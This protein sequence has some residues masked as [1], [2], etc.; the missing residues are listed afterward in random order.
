MLREDRLQE[1]IGQSA[2]PTGVLPRLERLTSSADFPEL[3]EKS[4][5][6][7]V[8]ILAASSYFARVL[9]A[10]VSLVHW[11]F[12][13]GSLY[14]PVRKK[15]I[16]SELDQFIGEKVD[17][18]SFC[19]G[20][21]AVKR[22]AFLRIG[23]RD[24]L[25]LTGMPE[26]TRSLS[27][28]A[29]LCLDRAVEVT[30]AQLKR[31]YGTPVQEPE[32][33]SSK[34]AKFV[35]M[36]MG[37]FSG[38]DLNFSSDVDLIY[39][40]SSRSGRSDGINPFTGDTVKPISLTEFYNKLATLITKAIGAPVDGEWVFRVDLGLRPGGKEGEMA[41]TVS[42]AA[43]HYQFRGDPWER[44]AL[45]RARPVA[46]DLLLGKVF[47]DNIN[48]FIFRRSLDYTAI[49][50]IRALKRRIERE[51]QTCTR[52]GRLNIKLC[53]GGIR[54]L[55]FFV[56][57]LQMIYGG[58]VTGL[59]KRGTLAALRA[60][61]AA[62]IIQEADKSLLDAGYRFLRNVE[63]RLQ[64]FDQQQ[65]QDL[66][67]APEDLYRLAVSMGFPLFEGREGVADFLDTLDRVLADVR[68]FFNQLFHDPEQEGVRDY[69]EKFDVLMDV[70]EVEAK[71]TLG[72]IGFTN[73]GAAF[74]CLKRFVHPVKPGLYSQ[75]IRRHMKKTAA[76]FLDL[77]PHL[78]NPDRAAYRFGQF[79]D[80]IG[81][82]GEGIY[83]LLAENPATLTL[84]TRIFSLSPFLSQIFIATPEMLDS[85]VLSS[86]GLRIKP[87]GDMIQER[88]RMMNQT[89]TREERYEVLRRYKNEE[90]LRIGVHHLAGSLNSLEAEAQLTSMA[91]V[92]LKAAM[93]LAH[94]DLIKRYALP[95]G[96]GK[97]PFAIMGLGKLGGGELSYN[98]DL[99]V[100]FVYTRQRGYTAMA[101]EDK[102]SEQIKDRLTPIT[103]QEYFLRLAQRIISILSVPLKEGPGYAIDSELRPS[104]TFGPLVVSVTGFEEYHTTS[105]LWERQA[106]L[107]MNPATGNEELC[108]AITRLTWEII[109]Q[110]GENEEKIASQIRSMRDRIRQQRRKGDPKA[111]HLKLDPGG[112]LDVEFAVQCLQLKH[113]KDAP[114]VLTPNTVAA[115]DQ[116]EQSGIMGLDQAESMRNGYVFLKQLDHRMRLMT[117]LTGDEAVSRPEEIMA[118]ASGLSQVGGDPLQTLKTIMTG[119]AAIAEEI[120]STD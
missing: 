78:P 118:G 77:V 28:L 53:H 76:L 59:R 67:T 66:P 74:E 85:L 81:A 64:M 22:R 96:D 26:T 27:M 110:T 105:Q 38:W 80:R 99:D 91:R 113:G 50:E 73:P 19:R 14:Q 120:L 55:E 23:S 44:L 68:R 45:M 17:F 1:L 83:A 25:G 31:D 89:A 60:L 115:I 15:D 30:T 21:R 109:K 114:Q 87:R 4:M 51:G 61:V 65:T 88:G 16:S 43:L 3:D 116:L 106:L 9:A 34:K 11:L 75:S 72:K 33:G 18:D 46:G 52:A 84:L 79:R 70:P 107:K 47:L 41:Q 103:F 42:S 102:F 6:H 8:T 108:L 5:G 24:L 35:V 56:Q 12:H 95:L 111:I 119:I 104:G 58:R 37:K 32:N 117:N 7:L 63:H 20:L 86:E 98:S 2:D 49:E 62:G 71:E 93:D 13:D 112:L 69:M 92:A 39:L 40:Y 29:E 54:S 100:I 90:I 10:D 97:L 57:T 94:Q 82:G 101:S 48:S 36:G